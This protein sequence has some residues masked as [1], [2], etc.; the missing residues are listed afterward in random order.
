[1]L[2]CLHWMLRNKS[3]LNWPARRRRKKAR[4]GRRGRLR[5]HGRPRKRRSNHFLLSRNLY[6]MV[7]H[8]VCLKCCQQ[9]SRFSSIISNTPRQNRLSNFLVQIHYSQVLCIYAWW[10]RRATPPISLQW[11]TSSWRWILCLKKPVWRA[12]VFW[13]FG[14]VVDVCEGIW[15]FKLEYMVF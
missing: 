2:L 7:F 9:R 1:M 5:K 6:R 14:F 8:I 11:F 15:P 3:K 13:C 12:V 10:T 4:I